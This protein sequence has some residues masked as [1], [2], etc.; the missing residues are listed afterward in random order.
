MG[1]AQA[2]AFMRDGCGVQPCID[3]RRGHR[4]MGSMSYLR[5]SHFASACMLSGS[6]SV[7]DMIVTNIPHFQEGRT[8]IWKRGAW[9]K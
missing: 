5:I 6:G 9:R 3:N 8:S 1:F 7:S 2:L 4:M